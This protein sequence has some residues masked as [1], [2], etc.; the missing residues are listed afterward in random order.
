M[1]EAPLRR[2]AGRGPRSGRAPRTH[3]QGR[4]PVFAAHRVPDHPPRLHRGRRGQLQMYP[5]LLL[6]PQTASVWSCFSLT[7]AQS[8]WTPTRRPEAQ[9]SPPAHAQAI[10]RPQHSEHRGPGA[11]ASA[12]TRPSVTSCYTDGGREGDTGVL[13]DPALTVCSQSGRQL[14]DLGLRQRRAPLR[15]CGCG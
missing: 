12:A 4:L 2:R 15:A 1:V 7:K 14:C 10:R 8:L 5:L 9:V 13:R 3:P 11:S 6:L